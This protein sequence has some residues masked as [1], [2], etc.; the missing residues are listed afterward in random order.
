MIA[1][2]TQ[3]KML[4]NT[5]DVFFVLALAFGFWRGRKHGMTK[6]LIPVSLWIAIV[7]CAGFGCELLGDLFIQTGFV[8]KIFQ[9]SV[10]ERTAAYISG[11]LVITGLVVLVFS[12]VK[13][14]VKR[15]LEGSNVFGSSEYY[16]GIISGV[17][18]YFCIVLFFMALLN[19][20]VYSKAELA[21]QQ[22][23]NNRWYGG[24]LKDY[25][26]DFIPTLNELQVSVFVNSLT[27]PFIK[28]WF[29]LLLINTIPPGG[30]TKPPVIDIQH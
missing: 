4:F 9:N 11:Y 19:A 23:Y 5:F 27:G 12:F 1:A 10:S 18:R 22:A 21:A 29:S 24:G 25:K 14:I 7:I 3:T 30:L 28:D 16:F 20:P 6:E 26:G 15:R 2:V 13:K 17:I 8:K